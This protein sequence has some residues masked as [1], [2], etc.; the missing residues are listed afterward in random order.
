M[1]P[2]MLQEGKLCP[3]H[4]TR[5]FGLRRKPGVTPEEVICMAASSPKMGGL[6][7]VW[8]SGSS[9]DENLDDGFTSRYPT[10]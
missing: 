1:S 4:P 3:R 5:P 2:I 10:S 9:R 6:R 8:N 7:A